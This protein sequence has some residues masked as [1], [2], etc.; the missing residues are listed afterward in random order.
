MDFPGNSHHNKALDT[1]KSPKVQKEPVLKVVS[2]DVIT[3]K[4]PLG[5]RFKDVFFGG[6]FKSATHY[7]TTEVLL[8]A[9]KNLIVDATSK[10]VERVIYG[11]TSPR[12]RMDYSRTRVSYNTSPLRDVR[13]PRLRG[14]LPDQPPLG[15]RG[16]RQDVNDIVLVSRGDAEI[17]IERLGDIID[18]Y[19]VAS[20][21]DLHDLVGLPTTYVDNKWGWT[22]LAYAEIKQT[23]EGYLLDLPPVEPI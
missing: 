9:L 22:N 17:V 8:P 1:G 13:D 14:T 18:K 20:V 6:E 4:K 2:S 19:E 16:R 3:K 21:A 23:R 5:K 15:Y 7:V 12:R 11:D 10:G